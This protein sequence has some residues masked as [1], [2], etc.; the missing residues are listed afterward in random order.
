MNKPL[1]IYVLKKGEQVRSLTWWEYW[2]KSQEVVI[3]NY[4]IVIHWTNCYKI[5]FLLLITN[6]S[7]NFFRYLQH[8]V[9]DSIPLN[10]CL[11]L[12]HSSKIV[13]SSRS[14]N[15]LFCNVSKYYKN[16]LYDHS[17]LKFFRE[18]M[19]FSVLK[20]TKYENY[21]W[22]KVNFIVSACDTATVVMKESSTLYHS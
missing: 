17:T 10:L 4:L 11:P 22:E 16:V 1:K 9:N 6:R 3:E 12:Y 21:G 13:A 2:S 19:L 20:N 5:I 14:F 8:I 7:G 15:P 18:N